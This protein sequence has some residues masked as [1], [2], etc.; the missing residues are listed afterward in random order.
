MGVRQSWILMVGLMLAGG[1]AAWG[2]RWPVERF[3]AVGAAGQPSTIVEGE[4]GTIWVGTNRG[5]R[6]VAGG[7]VVEVA[8]GPTERI[9]SPM[10]AYGGDLWVATLS[11]LVVVR[12]GKSQLVSERVLEGAIPS[13]ARRD[14][15]LY[16]TQ[17]IGERLEPFRMDL[18]RCGQ[19]RECKP[20]TLGLNVSGRLVVGADG[21]LWFPC[22]QRICRWE[23]VGQRAVALG[24]EAG[25]PERDWEKCL[26][27]REGTRWATDSIHVYRQRAGEAR[28]ERQLE[29]PQGLAKQDAML[30]DHE[31]HM[32]ASGVDWLWMGWQKRLVSILSLEKEHVRIEALLR[33]SSGELWLGFASGMVARM[34]GQG[35]VEQW[36]AT[37]GYSSFGT[38]DLEGEDGTRWC[39]WRGKIGYLRPGQ[40]KWD[41]VEVTEAKQLLRLSW[42]GRERIIAELDA[43]AI[44]ELDTK[45]L[46]VSKRKVEEIHS[47]GP[48]LMLPVKEGRLRVRRTARG[49]ERHLIPLPGG[50]RSFV[51]DREGRAWLVTMG[52]LVGVNP[53][54][55]W[56]VFT[57]ADGLRMRALQTAALAPDGKLWIGYDLPS[58][59]AVIPLPQ[60][61]L[62]SRTQLGITHRPPAIPHE[63][64]FGF[65][66]DRKGRLWKATDLGFLVGDAE[67]QASNQWW[68]M[69]ER[70]GL[71]H[72]DLV[73]QSVVG[74]TGG[75]LTAST[76]AGWVR[77]HEPERLGQRNVLVK[78]NGVMEGRLVRLGIWP[79]GAASH[80]EL[81]WREAGWNKEWR[82]VKGLEF[83][84]ERA[85]TGVEVRMVAQPFYRAAGVLRL[86]TA[87]WTLETM[88]AW[89]GWAL[90]MGM[91]ALLV[92]RMR[93]VEAWWFWWRKRRYQ[94]PESKERPPV[95]ELAEGTVLK[96]RFVIGEKLAR[97]TFSD[98]YA[99]EDQ[100]EDRRVVVKRLKLPEFSNDFTEGWLKRRFM[101]EVGAAAML[102]HPGVLPILDA[103]IETPATP[104]L[105]MRRVEGPTLRR[106][107]DEHGRL[108][109]SRTVDWLRQLGAVMR[110]AHRRGI[111]HCDLKPENVM[112]EPHEGELRLLVIDFGT[113]ALRLE[114]D[115]L[116]SQT[117][118][119]GTAAYAAP[120]Q[121]M[122]RYSE[123]SDLYAFALIAFE[124]LTGEQYRDLDIQFDD[125]WAEALVKIVMD[126]GYAE[127]VGE[128]LERGLR[129]DPQKRDQDLWLWSED[130]IAKLEASC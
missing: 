105:V 87:R 77:I 114:S 56:R 129:F 92:W 76:V 110:E 81:E 40:P 66:W 94:E 63:S 121:W 100:S 28:M 69:N 7:K 31:G 96:G 21:A 112:L 8:G 101:Q 57:E 10:V 113:S 20:E 42:A 111:I 127:G 48:T 126:R 62:D 50:Y 9:A 98:I 60:G 103:W 104:Y 86:G 4:D 22:G 107:L 74:E 14:Q 72:L 102:Q 125:G 19:K 106:Y 25:I 73:M 75:A 41:T 49:E 52:G 2:Q 26:V 58:D 88:R 11:G 90:G 67:G 65:W 122:G 130:L 16:F 12:E 1:G 44:Y 109:V 70:D 64:V 108:E 39:G 23:G 91:V 99:A 71:P 47:E 53:D 46:Q 93:W 68:M 85:G 79:G 34:A 78:L 37:E 17:R 3:V 35:R 24:S 80:V 6:R 54:G 97:G 120:E 33:D 5:L 61:R 29:M 84:V 27:D 15:W 30:L 117:R 83:E 13:M 55:S 89:P 119:A 36:G 128:V 51:E 45:T 124:M 18:K 43:G 115:V 116:S 95:A 38:W 59:T 32:L 118:T 82:K 123:A